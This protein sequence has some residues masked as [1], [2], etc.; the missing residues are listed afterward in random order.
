MTEKNK[1][2]LKDNVMSIILSVLLLVIGGMQAAFW[3]SYENE[4]YNRTVKNDQQDQKIED[5]KVITYNLAKAYE[6][7]INTDKEWRTE[8]NE[9]KKAID[10]KLTRHDEQFMEVW[11]SIRRSDKIPDMT[12]WEEDK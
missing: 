8:M 2:W 1:G 11:K 10:Q 4:K 3:N 7:N 12:K 6:N 5:L 9:W